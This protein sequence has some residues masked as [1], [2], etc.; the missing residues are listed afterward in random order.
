MKLRRKNSHEA[1]A[2]GGA[3]TAAPLRSCWN[4]AC[5]RAMATGPVGGQSNQGRKQ[6]CV[7][8]STGAC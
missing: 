1:I 4:G 7:R 3:M 2:G 5:A 6:R 8:V